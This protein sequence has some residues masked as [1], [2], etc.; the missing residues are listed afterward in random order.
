MFWGKAVLVVGVVAVAVG[1]C[2][3]PRA[4]HRVE[5]Q[6]PAAA[7]QERADTAMWMQC[8]R[9]LVSRAKDTARRG[10]QREAATLDL[11][12]RGPVDGSRLGRRVP[13]RGKRMRNGSVLWDSNET[14]GSATVARGLDGTLV[15]CAAESIAARMAGTRRRIRPADHDDRPARRSD[16]PSHQPVHRSRSPPRSEHEDAA[17]SVTTGAPEAAAIR[18]PTTMTSGQRSRLHA[19]APTTWAAEPNTGATPSRTHHGHGGNQTP[20][21][22]ILPNGELETCPPTSTG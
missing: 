15:Q 6:R 5:T 10:V 8:A 13:R 9:S 14:G 7:A 11:E 18:T 1:G 3:S 22:R 12:G 21:L 2:S 17:P 20:P 4:G 16:G 19:A